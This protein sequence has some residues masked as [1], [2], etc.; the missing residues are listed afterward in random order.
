MAHGTRTFSGFALISATALLLFAACGSDDD[1]D[2][3]GPGG[4]DAGAETTGGAPQGGQ[5]GEA[6]QGT[7]PTSGAAQAG[8]GGAGE[9]IETDRGLHAGSLPGAELERQR[10]AFDAIDPI[11]GGNPNDLLAAPGSEAAEELDDLS[12]GT[13][14]VT[15]LAVRLSATMS[16]AHVSWSS[17]AGGVLASQFIQTDYNS[18]WPFPEARTP[19]IPPVI[20]ISCCTYELTEG[21]E[22]SGVT[23][24]YYSAEDTWISEASAAVALG[25]VYA[26]VPIF[27]P[28]TDPDV[29]LSHGW[30][31]NGD[32]RS[33]H[34]SHDY[35]QP[36]EE[37]DDPSFRVRAVA[38]GT[39]VA[40]YWDAWHGNVLV[41]E[42]PG[43]G[44]IIYRS[45]YF[46]LRNG[47][48]HDLAKAKLTVPDGD[49]T[50]SRDKY[51]LFA[52]LDDPPDE[53]WGTEQ[54]KNLVNVGDTVRAHQHI[55]W[56]GNTGPGGAGKGLNLD[57]T[58]KN[59][60][61][62]NN[63]LHFMIAVKHPT[64][65]GGEW[66]YVDPSG[67]Y[68]QQSSGCYDLLQNTEYD[69][70][71]A[72]FYPYFHGV[73]LGVFNFYLYYYGQM[74]RSPATFSVQQTG[75][76]AIAAG[77]FKPGLSAAWYVYD[78]LD[79]DLW[80]QKYDELGTA[81]FRLVDR[82][83]TL[84]S[85]DN[86]RHNGVFRPDTTDDYYTYAAQ[87]PADYQDS[88]DELTPQGYD[89]GDFFGYHDGNTDRI[90][91]VFV[92]MP[93]DFSHQG[94]LN[95]ADFT[96]ITNQNAEDGWLPVDVNVMEMADGT[97]LSAIY[98]QTNDS[99]MVH[100]GMSAEE[101]Q[102]WINYYGSEGWDL[103]VVQ[104]YASGTRYAAIWSD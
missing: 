44:D 79:P 9:L 7:E 67:V 82:S 28:Y 100:W 72:P 22:G 101:Y 59:T 70:L 6:G 64:W 75:N 36:T 26:Q 81:D 83:V 58:P 98:R 78:Y 40:K 94:L 102:Q 1:D 45:F 96:D 27:L 60:A 73:D 25:E 53:W 51:L 93:G 14:V 12:Q 19:C 97:Y 88:F 48:S 74:G 104:N 2:T 103:E 11:E 5:T 76:D 17:A 52:N 89:L 18:N 90:A 21:V 63:H 43:I 29:R 84:D 55:A 31:Y 62:V 65:T 50:S 71:L 34:G 69:R 24:T 68:E 80:Q 20:R 3:T 8:A 30:I 38:A 87:T 39:V 37:G 77:A 32:A 10:D 47:K 91:S 15:P 86:P 13:T 41:L 95:S 42:H 61:T 35:S 85:S 33:S 56:S 16:T 54:Q 23:T 92:P 57:G 49:E 99:R 4:G 46:H 66:A